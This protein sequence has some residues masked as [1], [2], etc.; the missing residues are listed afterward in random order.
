MKLIDF[1][2]GSWFNSSHIYNNYEGT[3]VYA[4]PEWIFSRR[5]YA[6]SLTVWSLGVLLYDMLCGNIPFE[7]DEEIL[8]GKLKW[9]TCL[10]I[11]QS[12]K[13]LVE[14]CL[15]K[16]CT[17]RIAIVDILCHDWMNGYTEKCVPCVWHQV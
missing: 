8:T 17:D 13:S 2:S 10:N 14:S 16:E 1:G 11:S 12:A 9:F 7:N 5:F 4:P 6:E 15:K 3:R